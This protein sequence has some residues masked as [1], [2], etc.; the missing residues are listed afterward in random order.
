MRTLL[1]NLA[2]L[3]GLLLALLLVP[4]LVF[5]AYQWAAR[6]GVQDPRGDL[7][8]YKEIPWA[9][10]H[11]KEFAQVSTVYYDFVGWRRAP[12]EGQTIHIDAEGFRW[13]P[14]RAPRDQSEVWFFGGS[15]AWG[16]GA[17]DASTIPARLQVH[18]GLKTFNFGESAYTAHQS[19]NLLVKGYLQGGKPKHVVFYDGA[20]EVVIKCRSELGF[21][22]T[23][24][25]TLLRERTRSTQLSAQLLGPARELLGRGLRGIA[26]KRAGNAGYDCHSNAEKRERIA[27]ALVL[28]WQMAR[29]LV[30]SHG[31]RFIGIL[32]PVSFTGKPQLDHLPDL[33]SAQALR[34]QYD[35][36]YAEIR[37][38]LR[39]AGMAYVDLTAAL[40]GCPPRYIDFAHLSPQGN[41][42]IAQRITALIH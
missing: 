13:H 35:S 21:Y 36:V 29:H 23:S 32:Q 4:P 11:F 42:H 1:I 6:H 9:K 10:Q 14:D 22:S 15:T 39:A 31:G 3:L 25:E 2:V 30:E 41:D 17:D 26:A 8:M 28:D 16:P 33:R 34:Q 24:Q 38:Q 27:A 5:D 12:F 7:P 20:N 40:D 18:S 37:R 19:L